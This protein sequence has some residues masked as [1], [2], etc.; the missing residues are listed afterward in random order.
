MADFGWQVG[1]GI[2][3]GIV[4]MLIGWLFGKRKKSPFSETNSQSIHEPILKPKQIRAMMIVGLALALLIGGSFIPD[5]GIVFLAFGS[6][7]L[8]IGIG[9]FT[10]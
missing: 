1:A 8:I 2:A 5:I 9:E 7:I 6:V 3:S 4:L 10:S